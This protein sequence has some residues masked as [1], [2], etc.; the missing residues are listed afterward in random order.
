MR[1]SSNSASAE[2]SR[3]PASHK[4]KNLPNDRFFRKVDLYA[5]WT[6]FF[7]VLG[8]YVY[9]LAPTVTLED[10]GELVV[11]ADYL[12]VPH[13]PGYPIW[14]L[15]SWFFQWIFHFVTYY[16]QPNPAW[17]VGL[18]SAVC[19]ALACA[20]LA[21]LV[22]RSGY[23]MV[24]SNKR[25]TDVLDVPTL[26]LICWMGGVTGGLLMGLGQG[27]WSQSVIVEVYSLNVLFE[28]IILL[29]TFWWMC[30][31]QEN[32]ILYFAAFAFGL[33]LTNHQ[34][35]MFIVPGLLLAILC[36]DLKLGRDC[37]ALLLLV[38]SLFFFYKAQKVSSSPLSPEL[39]KQRNTHGLLGIL[40]MAGIVG[41]FLYQRTLMTEW[42]RVSLIVLCVGIGVSFYAYMPYASD[43]NPPMNW[44]Y[45]RTFEGFKHAIS[46]GQYERITPAKIFG[47]P[48]LLIKQFGTYFMDLRAQYTLPIVLTGVIPFFFFLGIDLKGK[49][50]LV[51]TLCFFFFLSIVLVI[52]LNP[53]LDIQTL[54]IQRVQLIQ[55]HAVYALW[56][57]YGLIF[58]LTFFEY[59]LGGGGGAKVAGVTMVAILP[60]ILI[61]KNIYH[62]KQIRIV[63]GS[64][65]NGHDFGWQFGNYQ[66]R[67]VEAIL[68]ELGPDE[69]P[70]PNLNFPPPMDQD[71]IFYGGTDPGRFVPTYMIYSANVRADVFLITQNALADNTYMNV[72]RDLYGDQIWI[73]SQL[74]SNS[75]FQKYVQ[76]VKQGRVNPGASL[77]F[78][79]GRVSVQGVQGVMMINGILAKMIF[80]ANKHKHSFYIEESYVIPWMYPYLEPHGLILKINKNPISQI[81]PETV[82]NDRAFWNWYTTRLMSN[83]KFQRDVVARKT[84]SKLRS[85]IAGL[86]SYRRMYVE[87][88]YA[89]RQ[90]LELYPLSPEGNFRLAEIN[91]QQRKFAEAKSIIE[92]FLK[93]DPG[94]DKVGTYLT[95]ITETMRLDNRRLELEPRLTKGI[96]VAEIE[97]ALE[98]V[99]LYIRLNLNDRAALLT[100]A[101]LDHPN[102]P[103]DG[104][105]KLARLLSEAKKAVLLEQTLETYV[106]REPSNPQAWLQLAAVQVGNKRLSKALQSLKHSIDTGGE[107]I[108]ELAR[109]DSRFDAIRN[110]SQFK[111]LVPAR[112]KA[113]PIP[114]PVF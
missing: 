57:G 89:F 102:S 48:V 32:K 23:E 3:D 113:S 17:A 11:A 26:N 61:W 82:E 8:I 31:P 35:L 49:T 47:D 73:P 70:P 106:A 98:L 95:Q 60:L 40:C 63:G 7:V 30:R 92:E 85:A 12:G 86:Y 13:P 100:K 75:A 1:L 43:Q 64:E 74:D 2:D 59:A 81:P 5:F 52:F 109:K 51:T 93:Q 88:D 54:F 101:L 65:Q 76:D 90:A 14:T 79:D 45:P 78:Q 56:L 83:P 110:S 25:F 80:E 4:A 104:L 36:R 38:A 29:L 94:N 72:M 19:G 37:L 96:N 28:M 111:T 24:T 10:S 41:L 108:R 9:T 6:C 84:F 77:S 71:A 53:K 105:L 67:G 16:D 99:S 39:L 15:L 114:L 42:K 58:G 44:G 21:L 87:A 97:L 50:W 69:P 66:L 20:V 112:K 22:S 33:G 68:E 103:S 46:R 27:L 107:P 55:S 62:E 91:M 18:F 34:T